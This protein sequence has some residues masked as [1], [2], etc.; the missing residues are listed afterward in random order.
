MP[1]DETPTAQS[2]LAFVSVALTRATLDAVVVPSDVQSTATSATVGKLDHVQGAPPQSAGLHCPSAWRPW[3]TPGKNTDCVSP[4]RT[5]GTAS[6]V[7]PSG[8]TITWA[9]STK[10][11]PDDEEPSTSHALS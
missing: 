6:V 7:A 2:S 1:K 3:T 11:R 4:V 5:N 8:P 10:D 9:T